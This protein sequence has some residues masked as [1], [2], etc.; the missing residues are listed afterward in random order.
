MKVSTRSRGSM[1]SA[2]AFLFSLV[3][4]L[5]PVAGAQQCLPDPSDQAV[6]GLRPGT[7]GKIHVKYRFRDADGNAITPDSAMQAAMEQGAGRWNTR[8]GTTNVVFEAAGPNDY[9]D[10]I[11]IPSSD[12]NKSLGCGAV[13]P[14]L[15]YLYYD[16]SLVTAAQSSVSNAATVIA[17]ELGH[18]LGLDDAGVNPTTPTIMNN[19]GPGST[20]TNFTVPTT[21]PTEADATKAKECAQAA[22]LAQTPLIQ[23]TG[24]KGGGGFINFNTGFQ[25]YDRYMVTD[26]Y[27]C[28]SDSCSYMYSDWDYMGTY[29]Y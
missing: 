25:C 4:A 6:G 15:G 7:D 16:P 12:P 22:R 1:Y 14:L 28:T 17:H 9:A 10:L 5:A 20:C 8:T 27:Y 13:D 2:F 29:C 23:P 21:T 19:P 24:T 11:V 3:L 26:Y 18:F